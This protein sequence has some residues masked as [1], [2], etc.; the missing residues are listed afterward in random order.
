MFL[1]LLNPINVLI[2]FCTFASMNFFFICGQKNKMKEELRVKPVEVL[3]P[4]I[5]KLNG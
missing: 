2:D 5:L 1:V 3:K 4:Q